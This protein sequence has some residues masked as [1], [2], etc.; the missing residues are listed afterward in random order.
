M[1]REH[2]LAVSQEYFLDQGMIAPEG[3]KIFPLSMAGKT[4]LIPSDQLY[5]AQR[6]MLETNEKFRQIIP[7][8]ALMNQHGAVLVYRR[9]G[10]GEARLDAKL[11]IGLGG[12]VDLNDVSFADDSII[13]LETTLGISAGRELLEELDI[14]VIEIPDVHGIILDDSNPVGRVHVG[15][16][17]VERIVGSGAEIH[18]AEAQIELIGWLT[19]EQALEQEDNWEPWSK[20]FLELLRDEQ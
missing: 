2:I 5:L 16:A 12:H 1:K 19:P 15:I 6:E 7:Y 17:Q 4:E 3:C 9:N 13:D 14:S 18:A 8:T 20:A 10:G 11:S